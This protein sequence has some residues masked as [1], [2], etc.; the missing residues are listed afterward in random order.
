M[1]DAAPTIDSHAA[2]DLIAKNVDGMVVVD[3][4]NLIL[5]VNPA[6]AELLGFPGEELSLVGQRVDRLAADRSGAFEAPG[7]GIDAGFRQVAKRRGA[8]YW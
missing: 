8:V 1:N 4:D 3:D 2:W 6:G 5:F 7:V